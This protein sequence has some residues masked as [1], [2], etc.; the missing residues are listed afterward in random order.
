MTGVASTLQATANTETTGTLISGTYATTYL[1]NGTSWVTAPVTPAVAEAGS[2][3]S[4]FGL[5]VNLLYTAGTGQTIN[6]VSIR[7]NF[8]A[9]RGA[10][11]TSTPTTTS[12]AP[13]TCSV[14]WA[15]G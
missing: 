8:A 9:G 2:A 5:N 6:S 7:G 11:A 1:S 12:R 15:R 14:M 4:P 13:G 3:L 10:T